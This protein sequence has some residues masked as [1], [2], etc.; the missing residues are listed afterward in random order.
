V[1]QTDKID[2]AEIQEIGG[3]F[4]RG[5]VALRQFEPDSRRIA[6]AGFRI[7]D[8]HGQELCGCILSA[9]SV[10]Q[11]G[12]E[13]RDSTLPREVV[14]DHCYTARKRSGRSQGQGWRIALLW[15]DR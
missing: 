10:A 7:V 12:R 5:K 9:N 8:R 6:I 4:I 11:I 1:L 13:S 2:I 3:I 14:S 15:F